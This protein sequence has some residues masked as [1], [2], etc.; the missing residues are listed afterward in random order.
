MKKTAM[1]VMIGAVFMSSG[2]NTIMKEMQ[3][4]QD[5]VTTTGQRVDQMLSSTK[6]DPVIERGVNRAVKVYQGAWIPAR[7]IKDKTAQVGYQVGQRMIGVNRDF[8]SLQDV[9]ESVTLLTG[10]PVHI[11]SDARDQDGASETTTASPEPSAQNTLPS[12]GPMG[13]GGM[14]GMGSLPSFNLSLDS[15]MGQKISYSGTL[16][17]FFDVAASRFGVSWKWNDEGSEAIFFRRE[18]KTFRIVA[19]PGDTQLTS[20]I[21]REGS[22]SDTASSSSQATSVQFEGLSVWKSIEDTVN[23]MISANGKAVVSPATG[24]ITVTDVPS[25]VKQVE[26]FVRQQ[27][28][29]LGRQVV[30]N[31]QVLSVDINGAHD[32]GINWDLAYSSL[33]QNFGWSFSNAFSSVAGASNLSLRVLETA[34]GAAGTADVA[35]WRGSSA[36]IQALSEQGKVSQVTSAAVTTLNNQPVPVQ[37]GRQIAYLASSETTLSGESSTTALTPGVVSTGFSM[38]LM[39]HILE[40]DQLLLQYSMDLSSL[41]SLN[42]V[43]SGTSTIETPE[44]ETRNFL[45]RVRLNSG[46]TLVV[47]G[48]EQ[49]NIDATNAGVGNARNV[50]AGGSVSGK[51][52]R[53]ALVILIQPFILN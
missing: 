6:R 15:L 45:Q 22:G 44:V 39:P 21:S 18:T 51:K 10:V 41:L 13:M 32:Y 42:R 12:M 38:N 3:S 35:R 24:T 53:N 36:I 19:L 5:E 4:Y 33:S 1:A 30:I 31:V 2:C 8:S 11:M 7:Q 26:H 34:G 20:K 37:S 52:T 47:A 43:S 27:N 48:F 16:A 14:G 49:T 23:S 46:D 40:G 17:G 50:M 9:A 29:S 25:I 28:A